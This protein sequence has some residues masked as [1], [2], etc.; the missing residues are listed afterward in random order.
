MLINKVIS[1]ITLLHQ[2]FLRLN[3]TNFKLSHQDTIFVGQIVFPIFNEIAFSCKVN[4]KLTL[5]KVKV[6]FKVKGRSKLNLKA[7]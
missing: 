1:V 6:K 5:Y 7:G 2:K 4:C 3:T